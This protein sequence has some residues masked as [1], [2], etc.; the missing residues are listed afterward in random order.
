[1]NDSLF[2]TEVNKNRFYES[3]SMKLHVNRRRNQ[4]VKQF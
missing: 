4:L 2:F 3:L 1:M